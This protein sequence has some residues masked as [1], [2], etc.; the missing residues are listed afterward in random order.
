MDND[1]MKRLEMIAANK[2]MQDDATQE[3][4]E[5]LNEVDTEYEE[6]ETVPDYKTLLVND[7]AN[8]SDEEFNETRMEAFNS[9][10]E[11]IMNRVN[12]T[13]EAEETIEPPKPQKTKA[14]LFEEKHQIIQ[15]VEKAPVE[16]DLE[17]DPNASL[18]LGMDRV[19]AEI[20]QKSKILNELHNEYINGQENAADEQ[21]STGDNIDDILV[22]IEE[23]NAKK[24]LN[25]EEDSEDL[26]VMLEKL[27][28]DKTYTTYEEDEEHTG[29]ADYIVTENKDYQDVVEGV[30]DENNIKIVKTTNSERNAIL[31]KF[32]NSGNTVTVPLV[33]SG[34]YVSV[35]G[36]S[37]NEIIAMSNITGGS[38]AETTLA[39]LNALNNHIVSSSIGKMRLA[40]L[41]KVISY[42]DIETL[43]YALYAATYPE[44]SEISRSCGRCR[45]DYYIKFNTRDLLLNPEDFAKEAKDIRENVT[46]YKRLLDTTVLNKVVKKSCMNGNVIV[47]MK[48]PSIET[49]I[50]TNSNIDQ[51]LVQNYQ[52]TLID[53]SYSIDKLLIR[54]SGNEYIEIKDPNKIIDVLNK[55]KDTNTI[56]EL[57]DAVEELRPSALPS[58]GYKKTT[59]PHC[60]FSD[61][62]QTF[63]M[64]ELLF[65]SAQQETE[66][67]TLRWAAKLQ[68][69]RQQKKK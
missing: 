3:A 59:C 39:K 7:M 51:E 47:Y 45:N 27:E 8:M 37:A 25:I 18:I 32:S 54:K 65:M 30:L 11:D 6:V 10:K 57:L 29:P 13:E 63:S 15:K 20:E 44:N 60:G 46:T 2:T 43:Y 58:F 16:D 40:Q 33:N 41:I 23:S 22:S 52:S 14:E 28:A 66:M 35:S 53:L 42:Y 21:D 5:L 64:Q 69:R 26:S 68:K 38:T 31:D 17:N 9:V 12:E 36:A 50:S 49:Y 55:I 56:Y 67:A 48:H 1:L 4:E 19:D 62:Q 24:D 34:I 61:S